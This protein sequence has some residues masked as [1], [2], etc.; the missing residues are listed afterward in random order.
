MKLLNQISKKIDLQSERITRSFQGA[1]PRKKKALYL[2]CYTLL[3]LVMMWGCFSPFLEHRKSLVWMNDGR[4]LYLPNLY[5]YANQVWDT[6][7]NPW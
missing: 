6:T 3:F 1:S 5:Y 2:L 4:S 7:V